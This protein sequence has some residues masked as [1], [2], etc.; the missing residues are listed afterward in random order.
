MFKTN[1]TLYTMYKRGVTS[2][3]KYWI[4][5]KTM[6]SIHTYLKCTIDHKI[7][8]GLF[9]KKINHL[10]DKI[11]LGWLKIIHIKL[12]LIILNNTIFSKE[13]VSMILFLK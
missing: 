9:V 11:I 8:I 13:L 1:N 7:Q 10:D 5:Y 4:N 2:G 3:K 12:K 6:Q